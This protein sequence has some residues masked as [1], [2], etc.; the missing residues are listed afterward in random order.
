MDGS[1]QQIEA[2]SLVEKEDGVETGLRYGWSDVKE[3]WNACRSQG[4]SYLERPRGRDVEEGGMHEVC[5]IAP[6]IPYQVL[7]LFVSLELWMTMHQA[8]SPE[9]SSLTR[10]D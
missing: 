4:R 7:G 10:S 6:K 9:S 5:E 8:E 1:Q 3:V 2:R